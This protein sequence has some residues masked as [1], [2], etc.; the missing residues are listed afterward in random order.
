MIADIVV[1][2]VS[3]VSAGTYLWATVVQVRTYGYKEWRALGAGV[4]REVNE[5]TRLDSDLRR[6]ESDEPRVTGQL[7]WEHLR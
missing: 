6:A 3:L 1:G 2:T 5:V 7:A 4:G